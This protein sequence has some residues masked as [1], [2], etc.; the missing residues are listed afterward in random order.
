MSPRPLPLDGAALDAALASLPGWTL[1]DGALE[2]TFTFPS[3]GAAMAFMA[4]AA[5]SVE[6]MDHHPE[7]TNSWKTVVVRLRTHSA[8]GVTRLDVELAAAMGR[9]AEGP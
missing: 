3:F 8:K 9:I 6:A 5:A 7:W 4:E 1:R 2:R